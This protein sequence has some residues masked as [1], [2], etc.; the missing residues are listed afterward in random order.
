MNFGNVE[1]NRSRVKD[2]N[3]EK[4]KLLLSLEPL[5]YLETLIR[6]KQSML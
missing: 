6:R 2:V 3:P 1:N 5:R 4:E